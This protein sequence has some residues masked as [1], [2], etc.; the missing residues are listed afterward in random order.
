MNITSVTLPAGEKVPALGLG[1]WKMSEPHIEVGR[2]DEMAM[3]K[4]HSLR[5]IFRAAWWQSNSEAPFPIAHLLAGNGARLAESTSMVNEVV[6]SPPFQA[7]EGFLLEPGRTE[8]LAI[9]SLEAGTTLIIHTA[10]SEYRLVVLDALERRVMMAGGAFPNAVSAFLHGASGGGNLLK[11]G[12]IG[13]GLR[14]AL[15]VDGRPLVTSRVRS[16]SRIH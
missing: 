5:E 7:Q 9:D 1:A 16:I 15:F 3:R 10:N 8:G 11:T 14:M 12:W 6:A 13:V 2:R 4:N